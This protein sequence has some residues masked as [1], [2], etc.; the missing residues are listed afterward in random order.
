MRISIQ[1]LFMAVVMSLSF[2]T[3]T[4]A[5]T[6]NEAGEKLNEG[7]KNLK[8]KNYDQAIVSLESCVE[9]CDMVGPDAFDVRSSAVT[10]IPIAYFKSA[11]AVYKSKDYPAAIEK[12][13]KSAEIAKKYDNAKLEKNSAKNVPA[14]Y[15]SLSNASIK[16]KDFD[17]ALSLLDEAI[18]YKPTYLK[19]YLGKARVYKELGKTAELEA[20]IAKILEIKSDS[21]TAITARELAGNYFLN[22]GV[23]AIGNKNYAAA[24]PLLEKSKQYKNPDVNTYYY[25]AIVYNG[26]KKFDKALE[27]TKAA[28]T[29]GGSEKVIA[30]V[31]FEQGNALAGLNKKT[32]ACEAYTKALNGPNA[33]AANFQMKEVLKCK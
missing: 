4:Y 27:A 3:I 1:K 14:L 22:K 28:V 29:K 20:N 13:K 21:K 10:K 7:I 31:Y 15:N 25:Y 32:E 6:V 17:K 8:A 30:N 18:A 26:L 33:E 12:F 5:Q 9:I 23:K 19:G 11:V 24:L 16:R 2:T